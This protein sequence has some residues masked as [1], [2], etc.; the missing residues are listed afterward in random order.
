MR[1]QRRHRF[2]VP[3]RELLAIL[4]NVKTPTMHDTVGEPPE[5]ISYI[6][7]EVRSA[8]DVIAD[9]NQLAA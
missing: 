4:P 7:D 9:E 5:R 3:A 1:I 6:P 2:P 8:D